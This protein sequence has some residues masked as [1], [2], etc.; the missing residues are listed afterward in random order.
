[1]QMHCMWSMQK[2]RDQ[3]RVLTENLLSPS[4]EILRLVTCARKPTE[5]ADAYDRMCEIV[6][7]G[8][9]DDHGKRGMFVCDHIDY[10]AAAK[11]GMNMIRAA[12]KKGTT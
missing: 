2:R 7:C 4:E 5:M 10:A 11:R 8:L 9:C 1:M 6:E 12:L 3:N